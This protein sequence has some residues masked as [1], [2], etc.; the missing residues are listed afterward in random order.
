MVVD[1]RGPFDNPFGARAQGW[2]SFAIPHPYHRRTRNNRGQPETT[3]DR[4]ACYGWVSAGFSWSAGT[5]EMGGARPHNPKVA[6]SNPAPATPG[7]PRHRLGFSTP[8][9]GRGGAYAGRHMSGVTSPPLDS[10]TTRA[11]PTAI[12]TALSKMSAATTFQSVQTLSRRFVGQSTGGGP[13]VVAL[14]SVM[15]RLPSMEPVPLGPART[16]A[17]P[18]G[19]SISWIRSEWSELFVIWPLRSCIC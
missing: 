10:S 11:A 13:N 16:T 6:G 5:S 18:V 15:T 9:S 8:K 4:I 2:T 14:W 7:K 19:T 12:G 3:G 1:F 17:M